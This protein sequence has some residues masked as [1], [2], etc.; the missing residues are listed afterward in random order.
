MRNVPALGCGEELA[1]LFGTYGEI[2]EYAYYSSRVILLLS[3]EA[4]LIAD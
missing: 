1:K 4:F 3:A 2:E